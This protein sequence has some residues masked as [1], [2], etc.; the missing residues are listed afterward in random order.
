MDYNK[1]IIY[2]IIQDLLYG[3]L[4]PIQGGIPA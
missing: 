4:S 3:L 1:R 2:L